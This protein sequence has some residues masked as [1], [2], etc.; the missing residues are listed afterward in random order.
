MPRRSFLRR[1]GAASVAT[2]LALN[3]LKLEVRA[4]SSGDEEVDVGWDV[5]ISGGTW[6]GTMPAITSVADIDDFV[7]LVNAY[8]YGVSANKAAKKETKHPQDTVEDIDPMEGPSPAP[9][10]AGGYD[11]YQSGTVVKFRIKK[12]VP[13]QP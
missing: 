9:Q 3:G 7:N 5:T 12:I 1:S 8:G 6:T 4:E 2:V 10:N 11:G 13:P